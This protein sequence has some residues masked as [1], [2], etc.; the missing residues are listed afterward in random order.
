MKCKYHENRKIQLLNNKREFNSRR[1]RRN[2]KKI[3][4]K[5][6]Y[7]SRVDFEVKIN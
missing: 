7:N 4:Y 2:K 1:E 5:K 3:K 6:N